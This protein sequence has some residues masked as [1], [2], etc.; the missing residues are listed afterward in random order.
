MENFEKIKKAHIKLKLKRTKLIFG[1]L[2]AYLRNSPSVMEP[3]KKK[4]NL[5]HLNIC[6]TKVR[7]YISTDVK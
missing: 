5:S 1:A 6:L 3:I 4:E 7:K 2:V